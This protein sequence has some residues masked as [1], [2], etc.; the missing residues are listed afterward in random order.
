MNQIASLNFT[1]IPSTLFNRTILLIGDS[2]DR[3]NAQYTCHLLNGTYTITKP[4]DSYWPQDDISNDPEIKAAWKPNSYS[5]RSFPT[6]CH[7]KSIDLMIMNVFHFGLDQED[8]F[9]WKDQYGPP[10]NSEDRIEQIAVPL[11]QKVGREI[12]IL[13]FSSGVRPRLHLNVFL[14][15]AQSIPDS[16][17]FN[18]PHHSSQ[19]NSSGI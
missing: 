9:T 6:V 16:S 8:Y 15:S 7:V 11:V 5:E 19:I 2:I 13:E 12:D 4:G 1:S 17:S 10:Y 14:F 18:H 3:A